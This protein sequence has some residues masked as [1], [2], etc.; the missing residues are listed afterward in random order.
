MEDDDA[1][2][3]VDPLDHIGAILNKHD[4]ILQDMYYL[5]AM[6]IDLQREP[7]LFADDE[8]QAA[9][10]K[11]HGSVEAYHNMRME[12]VQDAKRRQSAKSE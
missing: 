6:L 11:L 3:K 9:M 4:K 5:I 8:V 12:M 7:T 1:T 2:V 10:N